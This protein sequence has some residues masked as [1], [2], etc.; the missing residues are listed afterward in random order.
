M[1]FQH[2]I[3][4]LWDLSKSCGGTS[5]DWVNRGPVF[6]VWDDLAK[7]PCLSTWPDVMAIG[8]VTAVHSRPGSALA[9]GL[10]SDAVN[11]GTLPS[12]GTLV[13]ACGHPCCGFGFLWYSTWCAVGN[14]PK[15]WTDGLVLEMTV[16]HLGMEM[17]F[18]LTRC[19]LLM[20]CVS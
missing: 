7:F 15:L 10:L 19:Y 18:W 12:C 16:F 2:P 9:P 17:V 8:V 13:W 1:I 6:G 20:L 4:W 3:S 5:D 14:Y 11:S